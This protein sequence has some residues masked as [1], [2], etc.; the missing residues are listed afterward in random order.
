MTAP[1]GRRPLT[2]VEIRLTGNILSSFISD[3]NP[4]RN[5]RT[6]TLAPA[7]LPS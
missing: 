4:M 3:L 2:S 7:E 5:L 1:T 6:H